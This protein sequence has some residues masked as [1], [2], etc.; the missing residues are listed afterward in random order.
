METLIGLRGK[1]LAN[2]GIQFA[3]EEELQLAVTL[4]KAAD[5]YSI[6]D[7]HHHFARRGRS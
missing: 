5:L 6:G 3:I 1:V 4:L 7:R 2:R